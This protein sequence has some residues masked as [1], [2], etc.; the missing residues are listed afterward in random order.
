MGAILE[1]QRCGQ[2]LSHVLPKEFRR[3]VLIALLA[4]PEPHEVPMIR[5]HHV[6]GAEKMISCRC[7]N[8]NFSEAPVQGRSEPTR[9]ARQERV[10][11]QNGCAA[12]IVFARETRELG[13]GFERRM[14][15]RSRCSRNGLR[16]SVALRV[17]AGK[18]A[19]RHNLHLKRRSVA[20]GVL[21]PIIPPL[22]RR[23][24]NHAL[25]TAVQPRS[26]AL[27]QLSVSLFLI[28]RVSKGL[29]FGEAG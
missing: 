27:P 26:S 24:T 8:K 16:Q 4:T 28:H 15:S 13:L 7:V 29:A 25:P 11:P 1:H 9:A 19:A 12:L 5:H 18:G 6:N 21:P 3:S 17:S 22:T 2:M 14:H 23:A 20:I 10:R